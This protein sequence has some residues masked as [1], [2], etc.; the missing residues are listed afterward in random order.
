MEVSLAV[1]N[2]MQKY[3]NIPTNDGRSNCSSKKRTDFRTSISRSF[4]CCFRCCWLPWAKACL[5]MSI[6]RLKLYTMWNCNLFM[7]HED[8]EQML[9]KGVF[10][11]PSDKDPI[12]CFFSLFQKVW[13][14][15][16]LNTNN[17]PLGTLTYEGAHC[18]G[19]AWWILLRNLPCGS[20]WPMGFD[21]PIWVP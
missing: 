20:M 17:D 14:I 6:Y 11:K 3:E 2:W 18:I 19:I 7:K 9:V 12:F 13:K 15:L 16:L 21:D 10:S 1:P 5:R 8:R 4:C